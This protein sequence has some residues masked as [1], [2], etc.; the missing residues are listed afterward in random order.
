MS[1]PNKAPQFVEE[2]GGGETDKDSNKK[3]KLLWITIIF[4]VLFVASTCVWVYL[5]L[6]PECKEHQFTLDHIC[7]MRDSLEKTLDLLES[8]N[9]AY[10]LGFG[11]L[12]AWRRTST[13]SPFVWD[14][15]LDLLVPAH[16]WQRLLL[17]MERQAKKFGLEF[18]KVDFGMQLRAADH[19][20][21]IMKQ[22]VVDIFL[23]KEQAGQLEIDHPAAPTYRPS[24][25]IDKLF[26]PVPRFC[27][28]W[29]LK[30]RVPTD[31]DIVDM[32]L[33]QTYGESC[34]T[35]AKLYNHQPSRHPVCVYELVYY[36][37]LNIGLPQIKSTKN[38]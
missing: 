16:E 21:D 1:Q 32:Y 20:K 10:T 31:D 7:F 18:T 3:T 29:G 28:F 24:I 13:R 9:I 2:E 27:D 35:H 37:K 19:G 5:L 15:D 26:P 34:L 6:N 30:V 38:Q 33:Y 8:E 14:D 23:M 22:Y 12:L 25:T 4:V 17:L 11:T 36:P